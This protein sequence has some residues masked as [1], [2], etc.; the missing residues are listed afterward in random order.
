MEWQS[1]ACPGVA[2]GERDRLIQDVRAVLPLG[3]SGQFQLGAKRIW[4]NTA[5][6]KNP[7][8]EMTQFYT[9][10]KLGW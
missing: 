4:E 3:K 2:D 9:G 10:F 5:E 7:W 1:A 6:P 8:A